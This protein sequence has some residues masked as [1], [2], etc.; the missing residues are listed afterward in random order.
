MALNPL[1]DQS[2]CRKEIDK[3]KDTV[4]QREEGSELPSVIMCGAGVNDPTAPDAGLCTK[5]HCGTEEPTSPALTEGV[6]VPKDTTKSG[7]HL[8]IAT[9]T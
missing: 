7:F 8:A 4:L 9:V 5:Q 6:G 3:E 1:R 2:S